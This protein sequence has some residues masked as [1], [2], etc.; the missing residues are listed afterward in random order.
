MT[1]HYLQVEPGDNHNGYDVYE[2]DGVTVMYFPAAR[3]AEIVSDALH[4]FDVDGNVLGI[5]PIHSYTCCLRTPAEQ[6]E[7]D[8]NDAA[9][10]AH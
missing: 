8:E 9:A 10:A 1:I 6:T 5:Y 2:A 7:E 4:L 3:R